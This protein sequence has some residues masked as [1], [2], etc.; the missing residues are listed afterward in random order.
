MSKNVNHKCLLT[1]WLWGSKTSVD[2]G[3]GPF[4]KLERR[5][6]RILKRYRLKIVVLRKFTK[7][8]ADGVHR[9]W[10]CRHWGTC[11]PPPVLTLKVIKIRTFDQP[12]F[13]TCYLI[14]NFRP[15]YFSYFRK[16][17]AIS[18]CHKVKKLVD[19]KF[20]VVKGLK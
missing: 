2:Y 18:I 6:S 11:S 5:F 19:Q 14:F 20:P 7:K 1:P 3:E 15:T 8:S 12:Q 9:T 4:L 10:D 13:M 16:M 17:T